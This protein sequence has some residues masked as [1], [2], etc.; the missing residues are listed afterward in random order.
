MGIV[1]RLTEIARESLSK[2]VIHTYNDMLGLF[3]HVANENKTRNPNL[4]A[5]LFDNM[6]INDEAM[7]KKVWSEIFW[8][9]TTVADGV[10]KPTGRFLK[11][12]HSV[13]D[14][15]KLDGLGTG[16]CLLYITLWRY[17]WWKDRCNAGIKRLA[18][19]TRAS[20]K[21]VERWLHGHG[22]SQGLAGYRPDG[23]ASK[24][25]ITIIVHRIGVKE[26]NEYILNYK[27]ITLPK[28]GKTAGHPGDDDGHSV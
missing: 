28:A 12:P 4:T 19:D 11:I 21:S 20:T 18:R 8:D 17:C 24:P 23:E 1:E 3:S 7:P 27:K 13:L 16:E 5:W 2:G 9:E 25:L 15:P 6:L 22:R 14:D 10:A 26:K